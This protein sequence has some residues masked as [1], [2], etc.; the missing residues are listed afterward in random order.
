MNYFFKKQNNDKN[1]FQNNI[2]LGKGEID[3]GDGRR[4]DIS[5]NRV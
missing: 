4:N 1:K 3:F 5:K 2:S